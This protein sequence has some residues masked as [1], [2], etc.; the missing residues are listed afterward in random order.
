LCGC[1]AELLL[2]GSIARCARG[3]RYITASGTGPLAI[4][5][6]NT[7]I[8]TS[9]LAPEHW[10]DAPLIQKSSLYYVV[11]AIIRILIGALA[12]IIGLVTFFGSRGRIELIFKLLKHGSGFIEVFFGSVR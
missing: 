9:R 2:S 12:I 6:D 11:L 5:I 4:S 3:G 1:N 8:P 7:M 10:L